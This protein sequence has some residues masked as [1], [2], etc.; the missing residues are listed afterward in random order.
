MADP[1]EFC[2]TT[3]PG[4]NLRFFP[5]SRARWW[6]PLIHRNISTIVSQKASNGTFE[7]EYLLV[8]EVGTLC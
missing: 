7:M 4:K 1:G 3:P 6:T 2:L 5:Q 8:Y